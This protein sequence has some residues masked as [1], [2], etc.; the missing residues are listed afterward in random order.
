MGELLYN[1]R[2]KERWNDLRIEEMQAEYWLGSYQLM[3][4]R[5]M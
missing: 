2:K 5:Q 3:G 1:Q 4:A